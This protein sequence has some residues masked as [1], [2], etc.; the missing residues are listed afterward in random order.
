MTFAHVQGTDSFRET[1]HV[2]PIPRESL[3]S[4]LGAKCHQEERMVFPVFG[5]SHLSTL[6]L[7]SST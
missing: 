4:L 6:E 1:S 5:P 3:K 7:F 2:S